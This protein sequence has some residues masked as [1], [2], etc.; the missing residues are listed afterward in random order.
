MT[1]ILNIGEKPSFQNSLHLEK[2][3]IV[4]GACTT[5]HYGFIMYGF[6]S[7]LGCFIYPLNFT[8]QSKTQ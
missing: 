3:G 5:K 2:L 1:K 4:T 7:K 6:R 8:D